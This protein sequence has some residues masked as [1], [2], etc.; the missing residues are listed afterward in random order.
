MFIV[1]NSAA[2]T[3]GAQTADRV[4]SIASPQGGSSGQLDAATFS[5]Q[6]I[7]THSSWSAVPPDWPAAVYGKVPHSEQRKGK[8]PVSVHPSAISGNHAHTPSG[9]TD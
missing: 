2:G 3:R 8:A 4:S 9:G 6:A 1:L 7:H 5:S